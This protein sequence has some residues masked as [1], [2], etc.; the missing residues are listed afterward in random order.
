MNDLTTLSQVH[1]AQDALH[2]AQARVTVAKLN[3]E[4]LTYERT[5]ALL[6]SPQPVVVPWNEYPGF[7][8][9]PRNTGFARR[10]YFNT[11]PEDRTGGRYRPIY[12]DAADVRRIRAQAR[13]MVELYPVS[14]ALLRKLSDYIIGTGWDF[15]V[16]PKR[17]YKND[18]RAMQL[19]A[20][21]QAALDKHLEYNNFVGNLDRE[22]HEQSRM[23]GDTFATLY[24]EEE[25]VRI[26]LTDPACILEPA[27][28]QP[29]ERMLRQGHKLNL[30]HHGVHTQFNRQLKRDDVT[31][32][33][34]YHAVFDNLGDQWDYLPASRVEHVKRNLGQAARVGVSDFFF[35]QQDLETEAK[36]R[37]NTAEGAAILAAIVMIRQ[38]A[39]GTTRSSIESMVSDGASSSYQRQGATTASTRYNEQAVPGTIKDIP[40]GMT[41]TTGPMGQLRSPVY[42]EVDQHLLRTA[43]NLWSMPEY[44]STGDASN[45]NYSSTLVAESPFVKYAE[46]EQAY[47]GG[48]YER[49]HWK[50]LKIHCETGALKGVPFQL[51]CEM[52]EINGEY[53]SPASRDPVALAGVHQVYSD[54][55]VMS[56]RTVAADAGLD[57]D[58]ELANGAKE[59][60]PE[61]VMLPPG[62]KQLESLAADALR[63]LA[64]LTESTHVE[65]CGTG[66]GGFK[67]G[68]TC[69]SEDGV[70]DFSSP[71]K[72]IKK[73]T[74]GKGGTP[75]SELLDV[76]KGHW[77]QVDKTQYQVSTT[78]KQLR[79]ETIWS[80]TDPTD[81]KSHGTRR[82]LI[83]SIK[84]VGD[85]GY[86][87][88]TFYDDLGIERP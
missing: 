31:R 37:R 14:R 26:E 36:L 85:S 46:A 58:E 4:A 41:A 11:S 67:G 6:E 22:I 77:L 68:N 17:H 65:N 72:G 66:A 27:Q 61:P 73:V 1:S 86:A 49:L 48:H 79:K 3:A 50:A 88:F 71:K 32:P 34:G 74:A 42:I 9:W 57:L 29:L 69:A 84:A 64:T 30:W 8:E 28:P 19:A 78:R 80:D 12:E 18:P 60:A 21:V 2:E 16:K 44:M 52:L 15:V 35:V 55:G 7:D 83:V 70:G 59:A 82:T 10:P 40:F 53:K 47:Y 51:L 43:G 25:N 81:T 38:H 56:K 45:A 75:A 54:M 5:A 13:S 39:E 63:S 76:K 20:Q 87:N 23:D 24:A 33:I 62:Q